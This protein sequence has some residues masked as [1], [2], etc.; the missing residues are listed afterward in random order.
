MDKIL[1]WEAGSAQSVFEGGEPV[2]LPTHADASVSAAEIH[3]V[4]DELLNARKSIGIALDALHE[5]SL[6]IRVSTYCE[7]REKV[8][9]REQS[10]RH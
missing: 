7:D 9:S 8:D 10:Q 3:R 5:A 6:R 2:P 1:Q 4:E